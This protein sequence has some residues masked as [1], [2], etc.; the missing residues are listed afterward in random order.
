MTNGCKE[1]LQDNGYKDWKKKTNIFLISQ[2]ISLFG[3]SLV[4]YAIIW[5]ITLTT[6]SG[7]MM[8][9]SILASFLP[10]ILISLFAGVWADRYHRKYIIM[11][12][13]GLVALATLVLAIFFLTGYKQLWLIFAVS[14]MRSIGSGIQSP[15]VNAILP[16]FVPQEK[17]MRVNG[18]KSS[19]QSCIMLLSP[20]AGGVLLTAFSV[21]ISFF[22]DVFTAV[23]AISIMAFLRVKPHMNER[24]MKKISVIKGFKQG[25]AY[26]RRNKLISYLLIYY[27]FFFFLVAP[28]AFLTPLMVAR[29][30]GPEVWRL[31]LN[32]IL[33]SG[34]S[35]LGGVL[36]SVWGGYK[37]RMHSIALACLGFGVCS[38]LLGM[39]TNFVFYLSIMGITGLFLPMF[40]T[41]EAVLIQE[42]VDNKMQGRVFSIIDLI[43]TAVMPMGMFLFGLL[44]DCLQIETLL[45]VTGFCIVV[46]ALVIFINN[47]KNKFAEFVSDSE[48]S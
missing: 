31:T 26:V 18:I 25:I 39:A 2:S 11:A 4:A 19:M 8:S 21:E 36:M 22:V 38:A 27:I 10:Q 28:A 33:F 7:L 41:A 44:A 29:S 15:S 46:L 48:E 34:G 32:E 35:V 37:N 5:Y 1:E 40:N 13:D 16:Q 9:I 42:N 23:I 20:A 17:L 6:S 3:S 12:S 24:Q 14:A 47:N 43:A 30:F 45:F